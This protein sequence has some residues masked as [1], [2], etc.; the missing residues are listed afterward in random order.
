MPELGQARSKRRCIGKIDK[1]TGEIVPTGER[2][3]KKK[4]K[5]EASGEID[6]PDEGAEAVSG[7]ISGSVEDISGSVELG[8]GSTATVAARNTA[9]EKA[10]KREIR[11]LRQEINAQKHSKEKLE[12][13][14]RSLEEENWK[15]KTASD[16]AGRREQKRLSALNG[17]VKDVS[18][19]AERVRRFSE[20]YRGS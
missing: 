8:S 4:P 18:E 14:I 1:E 10:L 6:A 5:P 19:L 12:S 2:G 3:R 20:E 7:S 17:L 16:K 11:E 13:R 15:L 9:A